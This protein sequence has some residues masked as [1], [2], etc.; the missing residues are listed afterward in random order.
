MDMSN[1]NQYKAIII[2]AYISAI[3]VYI[4]YAYLYDGREKTITRFEKRVYTIS[5]MCLV[6]IPYIGCIYS[7]IDNKK[8]NNYIQFIILNTIIVI[9]FMISILFK[10]NIIPM[11]GY[12]S[13]LFTSSDDWI[14]RDEYDQT[15]KR[16]KVILDDSCP[17]IW[18]YALGLL[19]TLILLFYLLCR[20]IIQNNIYKNNK[21]VMNIIALVS[22]IYCI[23]LSIQL[24]TCNP[25]SQN[26]EKLDIRE[27][28][29][30]SEYRERILIEEGVYE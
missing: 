20:I 26:K 2:T 17:S 14:D 9:V 23:Y 25:D 1:V 15:T 4:Y 29:A 13:V 18:S 16:K 28:A 30:E 21:I 7:I 3:I 27:R 10:D 5:M 6:L 22:L 19:A 11:V 24:N 8:T 12:D